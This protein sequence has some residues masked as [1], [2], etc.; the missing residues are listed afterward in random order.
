MRPQPSPL[1]VRM[2]NPPSQI[3]ALGI[4]CD[5]SHRAD[6]VKHSLAEGNVFV[7]QHGLCVGYL[8]SDHD[9]PRFLRIDGRM[10]HLPFKRMEGDKVVRSHPIVVIGL[11]LI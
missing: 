10:E 4:C 6:V 8:G 3:F 9:R 7:A 11:C 2:D 5:L 1:L